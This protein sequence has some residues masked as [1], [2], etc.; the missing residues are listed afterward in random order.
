M[1]T[2]PINQAEIV[3]VQWTDSVTTFGWQNK[4]T[5]GAAVID[6]VGILCHYDDKSVVIST[7]RSKA[8]R[9]LDQLTI[10]RS[11]ILKMHGEEMRK[12]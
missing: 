7:S 10:P 11:S 12:P 8:G 2:V 5:D 6:S 3:F 9:F 1:K 4:E